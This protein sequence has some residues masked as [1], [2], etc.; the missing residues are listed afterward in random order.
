[1]PPM[2]C[3]P[4]AELP[5]APLP[6]PASRTVPVPRFPR[7]YQGAMT[8]CRPS[9]RASLPSLGGTTRSA[10]VSPVVRPSAAA[11]GV[12]ELF[13]RYLRPGKVS[14]ND[15]ISYVPGEPAVLLPC[16]PTPAGPTHQAITMRRRGP[17]YVHGEGSR[18]NSF[19]GSITRLRHWL[20]TLRRPGRPGTTQDSLPAA[21]QALPDGIAYPQS[22]NERFHDVSYIHP[23]FPSST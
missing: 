2:C 9:R 23:P 18:I 3:L 17:R 1:M 7:Y 21:G 6:S 22:S 16:S 15:R 10:R 14:G 20:S 11:G 4:T 13:T 8:S 5:D 12:L 19:R